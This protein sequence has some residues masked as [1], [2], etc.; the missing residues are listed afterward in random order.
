M[1]VD[2]LIVES[3]KKVADLL[4]IERH[5]KNGDGASNLNNHFQT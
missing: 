2:K 3:P 4:R 1:A 5:Q